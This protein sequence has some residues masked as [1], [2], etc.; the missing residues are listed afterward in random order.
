MYQT[1]IRVYDPVK[2]SLLEVVKESHRNLG[3]MCAWLSL[4]EEINPQVTNCNIQVR[5]QRNRLVPFK[6][7]RKLHA[8]MKESIR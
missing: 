2:G 6:S 8:T 5:T 7:V 1:Q 3:A 4:V